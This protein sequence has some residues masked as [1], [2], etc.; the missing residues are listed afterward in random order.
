VAVLRDRPYT[1]FNFLVDLGDGTTEGPH[2]GFQEI[3]AIGM[4]VDVIEYRTGNAKENNPIKLTGLERVSDV[5]LKRGII[6]S[7]SLYQWLDQIRNG[8]RVDQL[9][10][11]SSFCMYQCRAWRPPSESIVSG[12][13]KAG[14]TSGPKVTISVMM[15]SSICR[16]SRAIAR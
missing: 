6:G 11:A 12:S 8:D 15:P 3:S 14:K 2:A 4:Q 16:T 9:S 10:H 5:T 1:T 7:L 13:A